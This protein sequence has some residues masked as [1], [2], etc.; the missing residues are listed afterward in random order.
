MVVLL[1]VVNSRKVN[2]LISY[3]T[4]SLVPAI[5]KARFFS[6][7]IAL[8]FYTV[9]REFVLCCWFQRTNFALFSLL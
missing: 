7:N 4:V 6:V 2:C 3:D 5:S 8:H 1:V 9:I